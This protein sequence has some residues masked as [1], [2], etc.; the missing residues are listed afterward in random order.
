MVAAVPQSELTTNEKGCRRGLHLYL[1]CGRAVPGVVRCSSY[2]FLAENSH[3][4]SALVLSSGLSRLA[5]LRL[6]LFYDVAHGAKP[7]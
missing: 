4:I 7:T 1:L 2:E 3:I 5:T 6:D